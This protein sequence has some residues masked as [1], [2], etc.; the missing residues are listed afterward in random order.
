M[1]IRPRKIFNFI[2]DSKMRDLKIKHPQITST[3]TK[4]YTMH[5]DAMIGAAVV[6]QQNKSD[7]HL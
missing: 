3:L 5:K 6:A 7:W 4:R 1:N 2:V